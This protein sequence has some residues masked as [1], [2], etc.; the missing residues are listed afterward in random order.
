MKYVHTVATMRSAHV[1]HGYK[2]FSVVWPIFG[3][4]LTASA[5]IDY[6]PGYMIN[7]WW[8]KP[9][10]RPALY[11]KEPRYNNNNDSVRWRDRGQR[12]LTRRGL[13]KPPIGTSQASDLVQLMRADNAISGYRF[14]SL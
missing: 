2:V 13:S 11:Y 12:L 4:L 5:T 10:N 9:Y 14:V 8:T 6:N 1:V 3:W 7:F